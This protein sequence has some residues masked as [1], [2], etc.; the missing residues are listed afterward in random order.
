MKYTAL[1]LSTLIVAGCVQPNVPDPLDSFDHAWEQDATW[2]DGQAEVAKYDA[3]RIVYGESR[4]YEATIYTNKEPVDAAPTFTKSADAEGREAFKHHI[5]ED[6]PT[7]NYNYHYSTM[8][9]VGTR[10]LKSLK[11]DVGSIED[12]GTTYRQFINHAGRVRW[13]ESSYFPDEGRVAGA[14]VPPAGYVF[15]DS[16]SVV[17]RGYPFDNPLGELRLQ[18]VP[19]QTTNHLAPA[20]PVPAKVAYAGVETLDLPIGSV[21]AHRLTVTIGSGDN[22]STATYWF[23]ADGTAPMLH[24]MVRYEGPGGQTYALRSLTRN[25]YWER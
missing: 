4:Q 25:A 13:L 24:V 9:Y 2:Y 20:E 15:Q 11:L 22:G 7:P 5:R 6:I 14:Y 12:C 3:T 21:E 17:L 1:L 18:V 8:S 23:A 16:L 10:D 19:D